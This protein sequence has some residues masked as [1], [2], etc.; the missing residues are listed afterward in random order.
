MDHE[1]QYEVKKQKHREQWTAVIVGLPF[2]IGITYFMYHAFEFEPLINELAT[3]FYEKAFAI[4]IMLVPGLF[5]GGLPAGFVATKPMRRRNR[6]SDWLKN[7][8]ATFYLWVV[9]PIFVGFFAYPIFAL[10]CVLRLVFF[11]ITILFRR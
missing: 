4:G 5:F 6:K 10:L 1:D 11:P 3:T 7:P 8:I 9:F 2:V